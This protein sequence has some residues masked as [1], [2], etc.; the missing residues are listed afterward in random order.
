MHV[1]HIEDRIFRE[2]RGNLDCDI[3]INIVKVIKITKK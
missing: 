2:L 3:P 1:T